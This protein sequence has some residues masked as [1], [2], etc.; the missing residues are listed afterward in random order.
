MENITNYDRIRNMSIDEFARFIEAVQ[1][2][3]L[4]LEGTIHD[5]EYP[6]EWEKWLEAE[7][8]ESGEIKMFTLDTVGEKQA[9]I[10]SCLSDED[11]LCQI[12]EEAAE[13]SQAALKLRRAINGNNPTPKSKAE[14]LNS[15]YEEVADVENAC[16]VFLTGDYA[17]NELIDEIAVKK[18]DRWLSRITKKENRNE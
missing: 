17:G 14:A 1:T 15:F 16:D 11:M 18:L 7:Y 12:A 5:L 6:T 13:L 8:K 9:Y 2:D 3:A 4:F 10:H